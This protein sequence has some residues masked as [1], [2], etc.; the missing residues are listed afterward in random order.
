MTDLLIIDTT[1][2]LFTVS[3]YSGW[4]SERR[5]TPHLIMHCGEQDIYFSFKGYDKV[6]QL[7]DTICY[8]E[9]LGRK[10]FNDVLKHRVQHLD[11]T[12]LQI[13]SHIIREADLTKITV[14]GDIRSKRPHKKISPQLVFHVDFTYRHYEAEIH[15]PLFDTVNFL[16]AYGYEN[17][18]FDDYELITRTKKNENQRV[19]QTFPSIVATRKNLNGQ[20]KGM[21]VIRCVQMPSGNIGC[22]SNLIIEGKKYAGNNPANP[23]SHEELKDWL[24]K[25]N[26]RKTIVCNLISQHFHPPVWRQKNTSSSTVAHYRSNAEQM[27][28]FIAENK[29]FILVEV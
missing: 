21:A 28:A 26:L 8:K 1:H 29:D 25:L 12:S 14:Q 5:F 16:K 13:I 27:M 3:D 4:D 15:P 11:E 19:I 6:W 18:V 24:N 2:P 17:I 22:L 9:P 20:P 10:N 23:Q 7:L